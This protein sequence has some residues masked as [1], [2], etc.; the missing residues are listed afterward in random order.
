MLNFP[1]PSLFFAGALACLTIGTQVSLAEKVQTKITLSIPAKHQIKS[2]G[3][4]PTD[5]STQEVAL[6]DLLQ[7]IYDHSIYH[8]K[9]L[10]GSNLPKTRNL[11]ATSPFL[12]S[13]EKT[14]Q[15]EFFSIF[16]KGLLSSHIDQEIPEATYFFEN[17][18][19]IGIA[20]VTTLHPKNPYLKRVHTLPMIKHEGKWKFS[21]TNSFDG[22]ILP[23]DQSIRD[24]AKQLEVTAQAKARKMTEEINNKLISSYLEQMDE[25]KKN[26]LPKAQNKAEIMA[27][28]QEGLQAKNIPNLAALMIDTQYMDV[29]NKKSITKNKDSIDT[30][31]NV[32]RLNDLFGCLNYTPITNEN[33]RPG[34]WSEFAKFLQPGSLIVEIPTSD[35][36]NI[37]TQQQIN[38]NSNDKSKSELGCYLGCLNLVSNPLER[39]SQKGAVLITVYPLTNE[40]SGSSAI[41]TTLK[42]QTWRSSQDSETFNKLVVKKLREKY[43]PLYGKTPEETIELFLNSILRADSETIFRLLPQNEIA[44]DSQVQPMLSTIIENYS[45][46]M[47]QFAQYEQGSN[48]YDESSS[49]GNKTFVDIQPM[50]MVQYNMPSDKETTLSPLVTITYKYKLKTRKHRLNIPLIR[51]KE[52][53][54][55]NFKPTEVDKE[56]KDNNENA[57]IE[58]ELA[59]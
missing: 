45:R 47:P 28:L 50:A 41:F 12:Q 9:I 20:Y 34:I 55:L 27:L 6:K 10:V 22:T 54:Q 5:Q 37:K 19:D 1:N 46:S 40:K 59:L 43:K 24:K 58:V 52:G 16:I 33:N 3:N 7:N 15:E 42:G 35:L 30:K 8:D 17:D 26:I 38:P 2:L 56:N 11:F 29:E 36:E 25:Y 48:N 32:E 21:L 31:P 13:Q 4:L 23:F 53:W 51:T 18:G 14:S 49:I 39:Y 44:E 57:V